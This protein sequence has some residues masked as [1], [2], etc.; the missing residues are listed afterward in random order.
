M[1]LNHPNVVKIYGLFSDN[2]NV[3]V[4]KE[5]M[6]D[7]CVGERRKKSGE[8]EIG[9]EINQV[10]NGILA[11]LPIIGSSWSLDIKN[12]AQTHVKMH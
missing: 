4:I 7:G 3:Y 10:L 8:A 12:I 2:D 5:Y 9:C 6:E 11:V 1:M